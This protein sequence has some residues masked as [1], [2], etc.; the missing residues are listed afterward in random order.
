MIAVSAGYNL[1]QLDISM[2]IW[3]YFRKR[4]RKVWVEECEDFDDEN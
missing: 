4:S 2:R 1:M 3:K